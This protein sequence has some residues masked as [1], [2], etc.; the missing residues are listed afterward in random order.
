[1]P[2]KIRLNIYKGPNLCTIGKWP[3]LWL[4]QKVLFSIYIIYNKYKILL[5]IFIL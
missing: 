5:F 1:M 4:S 2:Y 3:G